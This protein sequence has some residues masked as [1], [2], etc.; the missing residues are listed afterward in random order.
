M[1]RGGKREEREVGKRGGERNK[2]VINFKCT[3]VLTSCNV[4]CSS[5]V[6][7]FL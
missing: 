4:L 3:C 6:V 7:I 1:V 2:Q 5:V